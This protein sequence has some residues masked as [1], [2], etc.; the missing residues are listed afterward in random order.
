MTEGDGGHGGGRG[1]DPEG[2][3]EGRERGETGVPSLSSSAPV[4]C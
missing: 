3:G 2:D 1:V 4:L